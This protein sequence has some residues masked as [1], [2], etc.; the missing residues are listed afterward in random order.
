MTLT[1]SRHKLFWKFQ[2]KIFLIIFY[3]TFT[4]RKR[5]IFSRTVQQLFIKLPITVIFTLFI[6]HTFTIVNTVE[7]IIAILFLLFGFQKKTFQFQSA[8]I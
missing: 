5:E 4:S 6:I 7:H 1:A 8:Y 3:K 2:P